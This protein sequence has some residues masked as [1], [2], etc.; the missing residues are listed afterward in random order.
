MFSRDSVQQFFIINFKSENVAEPVN[1]KELDNLIDEICKIHTE[2]TAGT[3]EFVKN[4][5]IGC[6]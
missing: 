2:A 6:T 3:D 5:V 1:T 4:E